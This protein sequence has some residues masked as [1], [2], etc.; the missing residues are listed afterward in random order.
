MVPLELRQGTQGPTCVASGKSS[1]HASCE[2]PLGIPRQSLPGPRSS[3]GVE[4][5]TSG[6]LSSADM[7][8]GVPLEFPQGSKA[9]SLVETRK[10]A[11]LSSWKSCLASCRVDIGIGG[12]FLRCHRAVTPAI[13]FC[14][15]PP[16]DCRVSAVKSGVS[17]VHWDIGV[18]GNGGMAPGVPLECQVETISS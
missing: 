5:R 18:F 4:A 2:G 7:D 17:G 6:F 12:F 15:N 13:V 1:L 10:S 8:L 11:L 3:S 14:V 16:G 9:S